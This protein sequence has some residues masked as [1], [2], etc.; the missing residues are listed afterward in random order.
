MTDGGSK[1]NFL[2][3]VDRT[4]AKTKA[5]FVIFNYGIIKRHLR[6]KKKN[7][8]IIYLT[9]WKY[10]IEAAFKKK[11]LSIGEIKIIEKFLGDLGVKN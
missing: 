9:N 2:D 7:I 5:I 11:I 10:I 3:A 1:L 4:G 6:F 8:D